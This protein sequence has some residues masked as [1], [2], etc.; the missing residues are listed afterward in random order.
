MH[1]RPQHAT[2]AV[3]SNTNTCMISPEPHCPAPWLSHCLIYPIV[4]GTQSSASSCMALPWCPSRCPSQHAAHPA[5]TPHPPHIPERH[6][7]VRLLRLVPLGGGQPGR[8]GATRR[9]CHTAKN[10]KWP[11]T[12]G[13]HWRCSLPP[14]KYSLPQAARRLNK[15]AAV[16]GGPSCSP[17]APKSALSIK[18]CQRRWNTRALGH[19]IGLRA[20]PQ[21]PGPG[22]YGPIP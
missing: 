6:G 5:P 12:R 15:G 19:S 3:V 9:N 2:A 17:A 18:C 8:W 20:A 4:C 10:S 16:A 22:A 21:M 13:Q 7:R 14:W 1:D 11:K